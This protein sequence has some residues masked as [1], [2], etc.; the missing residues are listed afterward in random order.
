MTKEELIDRWKDRPHSWSQHSSFR[1]YDK[2]KW[3]QFYV[4][5]I[6]DLPNKRMEW[7]SLVG[8]RIEKDPTY[9][10]QLRRGGTMEYGITVKLSKD[11]TLIGYMDQHFEEE[12]HTDEY[13]TSGKDGWNQKKVDEHGQLT[14]Y[15]LLL[16]LKK[17]VKPENH[18]MSLHHMVTEE[19]G[20]FTIKFASPFQLNTYHTKRTTKQC[21]MLGAEIIKLRKEMEEYIKNHE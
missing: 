1:D 13:K 18:T 20:D 4:L 15:G 16:M 10:P 5:G 8:K 9:I 12:C 11:I 21:L 19:E 17:K 2:E 6:K 14:F 3:Y 7:G